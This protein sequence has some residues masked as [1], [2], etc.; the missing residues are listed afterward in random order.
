MTDETIHDMLASKIHNTIVPSIVNNIIKPGMITGPDD[1]CV[2]LESTVVGV[3]AF[4]ACKT[5]DAA[6]DE[7]QTATQFGNALAEALHEG[8]K[9]RLP[10]LIAHCEAREEEDRLN[11]EQTT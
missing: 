10:D 2:I 8:I 6:A 9:A 7:N 11:K 1:V 3:L 5:R 4:L